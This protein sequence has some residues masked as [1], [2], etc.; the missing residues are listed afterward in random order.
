[1]TESESVALPLGESPI[2]FL[3]CVILSNFSLF[4]KRFYTAFIIFFKK[5]NFFRL[6]LKKNS[7]IIEKNNVTLRGKTM[8]ITCKFGGTSLATAA[9][10][11]AACE[12]VRQNPDRRFVVVSAPGKK[13]ASGKKVTDL[14]QLCHASRFEED[15]FQEYF[16]EIADTFREI[17]A[18]APNFPID[19]ELERMCGQIKFSESNIDFVMSRGE[20]L[21]AR[22]IAAYLGFTFLDAAKFIRFKKGEL[23]M[24]ATLRA[25]EKLS[26]EG[27][28]VIPG[29]YGLDEKGHVKTFS[30]GGSDI[31]GSVVARVFGCDLYENWT[32]VDGIRV[33]D[34]RIVEGSKKV[35]Q[36]SFRELR[37][38]SYMGAS[39]LH[40][41]TLLPV[42]DKPIPIVIKNSFAP[43]LSG[44]QIL[45]K[46]TEVS[47]KEAITCITGKSDYTC[48]QISKMMLDKQLGFVK[49][50]TT[51]FEEYHINISHTHSGLDNLCFFVENSEYKE[52]SFADFVKVLSSRIDA[53]KI[54]THE[55][56]ALLAVIG[57]NLSGKSWILA[58]IFKTLSDHSI[59]VKTVYQSISE[60]NVIVGVEDGKLNECVRALYKEL[61]G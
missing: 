57:H 52:I 41:E 16:Q 48:I 49:K 4:G 13:N 10:I 45:K 5:I 12:I 24:P 23:D 40:A 15:K 61:I 29:F 9:N 27:N 14:L 38:M 59:G 43:T 26:F 33:C 44:T 11:R 37:E 19:E 46:R 2:C 60:C 3:S 22:L 30:R 1:M 50:A 7:I 20:Y 8:S 25:A 55:K 56:L 51:V 18:L 53:D 34:P 31:T 17:A 36:V 42:H 58:K 39:V 28:F 47:A 32:D 54:K 21:N 35:E 6:T